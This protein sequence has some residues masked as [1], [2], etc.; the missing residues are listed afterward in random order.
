MLFQVPAGREARPLRQRQLVMNPEK[1][2]DEEDTSASVDFFVKEG[3]SPASRLT[4]TRVSRHV[5]LAVR[6]R[7]R[8]VAGCVTRDMPQ[9]CRI[10]DVSC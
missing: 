3:P 4:A 7:C 10:V 2:H 1:K 9:V 6:C 8:A 5:P